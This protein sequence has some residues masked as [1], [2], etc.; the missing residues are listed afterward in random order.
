MVLEIIE[1]ILP[2]LVI[3]LFITLDSRLCTIDFNNWKLG[4]INIILSLVFGVIIS[5]IIILIFDYTILQASL[6]ILFGIL[7]PSIVNSFIVE[8]Y[9]YNKSVVSSLV[10]FGYIFIITSIFIILYF[11]FA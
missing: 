4:L 1:I 2:L 7:L 3:F 11:L 8:K 5:F 9:A 10:I 6:L